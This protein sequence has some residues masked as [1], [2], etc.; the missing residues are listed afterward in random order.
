MAYRFRL[1][2]ADHAVWLSRR[3]NGYR[4]HAEGSAPADVALAGDGVRRTL[5]MDGTTE[6]VHLAT[7]GDELFIHLRGQTFHLRYLDPVLSHANSGA[8]S[9]G[10]NEARAPMPGTVVSLPVSPGDRVVA[11]DALIVIESMKLETTIRA[12]A[13]AEVAAV[14]VAEG[15]S[16]ERDQVLVTLAEVA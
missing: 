13:P 5:T 14:H 7:A 12:A 16:F 4:L 3:Q 6:P 15:A 10:A 11:G 8:K 2:S 1:G 9:G